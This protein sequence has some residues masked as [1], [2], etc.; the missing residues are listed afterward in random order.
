MDK[1]SM[2]YHVYI[3]NR[4]NSSRKIR[5]GLQ[6]CES[7]RGTRKTVA[8]SD[9]ANAI[10]QGRVYHPLCSLAHN[11]HHKGAVSRF[12]IASWPNACRNARRFL[13]CARETASCSGSARGCHGGLNYSSRSRC[14]CCRYDIRGPRHINLRHRR[15]ST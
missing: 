8:S 10:K 15:C 12:T 7:V 6:Q 2:I 5:D 3:P 14:I 11:I 13:C 4:K 1:E 9:K